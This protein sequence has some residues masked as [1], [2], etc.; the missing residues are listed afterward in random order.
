LELGAAGFLIWYGIKLYLIWALWRTRS[1]LHDPF[2][3]NLALAAFL[4]HSIQITGQ[5]VV[6]HTANFYFWFMAG[7]IF[8]LPRLDSYIAHKAFSAH[9]TLGNN[10]DTQSQN[11][12]KSNVLE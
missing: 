4:A 2:L 5:T 3:K 8:L 12:P 1:R 11:S 7:F 10:T 9:I 6:N